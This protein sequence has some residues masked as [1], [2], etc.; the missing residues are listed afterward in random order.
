MGRGRGS[1][2]SIIYRPRRTNRSSP[3][4]LL[5]VSQDTI[6]GVCVC[7][8]ECVG[9][10]SYAE[11]P[12][13]WNENTLCTH[14]HTHNR[15]ETG[16]AGA[17]PPPP[18]CRA[19]TATGVQ[20]NGL[21]RKY[22]TNAHYD[23][24]RSARILCVL[25][26]LKCHRWPCRR[27]DLSI[28]HSVFSGKCCAVRVKRHTTIIRCVSRQKRRTTGNCTFSVVYAYVRIIKRTVLYVTFSHVVDVIINY[29]FVFVPRIRNVSLGTCILLVSFDKCR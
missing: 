23:I 5:T 4:W 19:K 6:K 15:N 29:V 24:I 28:P 20:V 7:V 3:L 18:T 21:P 25:C 13:K 26:R 11:E 12:K 22:R 1:R 27:G 16:R 9:T 8:C 14:T 2:F 17:A 10:P